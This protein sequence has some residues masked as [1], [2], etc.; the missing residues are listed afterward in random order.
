MTTPEK[1]YRG[2]I[3]N[4]AHVVDIEIGEAPPRRLS[5]EGGGDFGW[6]PETGHSGKFNLARALVADTG[7]R[8]DDHRAGDVVANILAL[9]PSDKPWTLFARH[10]EGDIRASVGK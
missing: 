6:G 9:L 2:S 10:L 4:G 7:R 5:P 1:M 3:E 8:R